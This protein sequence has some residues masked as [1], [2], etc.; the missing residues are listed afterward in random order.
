MLLSRGDRPFSVECVGP[1]SANTDQALKTQR[2]HSNHGSTTACSS[3][4]GQR[5]AGK[6]VREG[7]FFPAGRAKKL[8]QRRNFRRRLGYV[9]FNAGNACLFLYVCAVWLLIRR[10]SRNQTPEHRRECVTKAMLRPTGNSEG[11]Q[12]SV[13]WSLGFRG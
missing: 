11:S 12:G 10:R 3:T 8:P 1:K 2:G 7:C 13:V 6:S 4:P 9:G 5:C